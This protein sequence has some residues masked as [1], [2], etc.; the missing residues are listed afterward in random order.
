MLKDSFHEYLFN[1]GYFV[2]E[3]GDA[4]ITDRAFETVISLA[5]LFG[6][7]IVSGQ[8]KAD[9]SMI[10]TAA[11]LLGDNIPEPFYRGFP[12][13][14]K[15][16]SSDELL[17][18]KLYS[19]YMTYGLGMFD[20]SWHSV[21][22]RDIV[23]KV[24]SEATQVRPYKIISEEEAAGLLRDAAD[25]MV[26]S[27]R[28]LNDSQYS[29][30]LD[31]ISAL[32][33]KVTKC[34]CK[35]T[36]VRL[37]LDTRDPEYA[38][39]LKLSDVIRMVEYM[40]EFIYKPEILELKKKQKKKRKRKD[41]SQ[42]AEEEKEEKIKADIYNLNLRNKDRKLIT[43]VLDSIFLNGNANI[44]DCCEKKRQWSGLLHHLHYKPVNQ[45]AREFVKI[46][47]GK[48]NYSAYSAFE[49]AMTDGDI[50]GAV[51]ILLEKKG[52]SALL[53]NLTYILSRCKTDEAVEYVLS[54]VESN[55]KIL[56]MQ[57]MLHYS[58]YSDHEPRTFIFTR[59]NKLCRYSEEP[60]AVILR[61]W[62]PDA[63]IGKLQEKIYSLLKEA[64]AGTLSRVYIDPEMKKTALPLQENTAMGGLGILPK[65]SRITIPEGKKIRGFT[66]WEQVN[67]VDL[68]VQGIDPDGRGIEFS[69]RTMD[70][71]QSDSVC[72]S[73]DETAGYEG[74]SEYFDIEI[75]AFREEYPN[76]EYLIF[77]NN[78]Y[79][80]VR[81]SNC[82]C[83]AGYML[84]DIDDSGEVFEPKT[85]ESSFGITCDSRQAYL[86][87]LDLKKREFI[88]LNLGS[89]SN[90]DV[91]AK[92]NIRFLEKYFNMT[93]VIN[94]YDYAVMLASEVV[95]D[96]EA[97]DVV[98]S[99]KPL[100]LKD[101]AQ[102]IR[103][104][105]TEKLTALM[106]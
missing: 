52:S 57:L 34:A 59:F 14:V 97:A 103:S 71:M 64:A 32:D 51:D 5:E 42:G 25:D 94:V 39:L 16:L 30:L 54:H 45:G 75:N 81:F 19:Y 66:Y 40:Q 102:Q 101:G 105:D 24:F 90:L 1:K 62:V 35:D 63:V 96:P 9:P 78:T 89:S 83:K 44:S 87:A 72:F 58:S 99:D 17:F 26:R 85:V 48:T 41:V 18:D 4:G 43:A 38:S 95:D 79:S 80:D 104:I 22:E 28:P 74:G 13:S 69:W 82:Y 67:D 100:K 3:A 56:L 27:T 36:I 86:F 77:C 47:R 49:K 2:A 37:I 70:E 53:R 88:W 31:M 76:I 21:L 92:E 91:A 23:R 46:I 15:E 33:Y 6:I 106:N 55:N 20:N 10:K 50:K 8:D 29:M 60:E 7:Q 61:K 12:E 65:G 68:S 98:F 11:A 84:R 73:G 93:D